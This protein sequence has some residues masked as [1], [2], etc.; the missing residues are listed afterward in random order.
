[1]VCGLPA[2]A[3]ALAAPPPLP[4]WGLGFG[5]QGSGFRVWVLGFRVQGLGFR[6]W[7]LPVRQCSPGTGPAP[8]H[9]RFGISGLRDGIESS[10]IRGKMYGCGKRTLGLRAALEATQGQ[11]NGFFSQLPYKCHLKEVA[12]VGN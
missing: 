2:L 7:G 12:S 8:A 9:L 4:V 11:M 10:G 3:R 6:V 5:I 1:M